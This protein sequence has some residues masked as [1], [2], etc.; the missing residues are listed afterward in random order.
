MWENA[1]ISLKNYYDLYHELYNGIDLVNATNYNPVDNET[2]FRT[3]ARGANPSEKKAPVDVAADTTPTSMS[4]MF[5]DLDPSVAAYLQTAQA[6]LQSNIDGILG[7]LQA[8]QQELLG[9]IGAN[10]QSYLGGI[11]GS[12]ASVGTINAGDIIINGNADENTVSDIRR[13]QRDNVT[14]ILKAFNTLNSR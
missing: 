2:D 11:I 14:T 12:S 1:Y 3:I 10:A 5:S 4:D 7:Q 13:A 6:A 8:K 9:Q